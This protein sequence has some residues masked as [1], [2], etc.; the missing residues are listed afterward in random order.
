M[1]SQSSTAVPVTESE[2][3][4]RE[5]RNILKTK[6]PLKGDEYPQEFLGLKL[7]KRILQPLFI[8]A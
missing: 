2:H 7:F 6:L 3:S 4:D 8:C 5:T 1:G